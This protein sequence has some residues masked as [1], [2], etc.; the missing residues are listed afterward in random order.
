M[1][2]CSICGDVYNTESEAKICENKGFPKNLMKNFFM[3]NAINFADCSETPMS[4]NIV[5]DKSNRYLY[6]EEYIQAHER[7]FA[8]L[9]G[10]Y[11][12]GEVIALYLDKVVLKGHDLMYHF[13]YLPV[14][15]SKFIAWDWGWKVELPVVR[16]NELMQKIIDMNY[17]YFVQDEKLYLMNY[18]DINRGA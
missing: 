17:K 6:P 10:N 8:L 12:L 16:G 3:Q 2:V 5:N 11:E 13:N 18:V 4:Y 15:D 14:K 7:N 1:Y 9:K